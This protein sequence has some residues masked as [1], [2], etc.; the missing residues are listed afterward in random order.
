MSRI[1]GASDPPRSI[2]VVTL[3]GA[4]LPDLE[5][6]GTA[7]TKVLR[8]FGPRRSEQPKYEAACLTRLLEVAD[9]RW[10]QSP[11]C[12]EPDALGVSSW[13]AVWA[14]PT[15]SDPRHPPG[16]SAHAVDVWRETLTALGGDPLKAEDAAKR[17]ITHRESL[18]RLHTGTR[19]ALERI[20]TGHELWLAT[21]GSSALQRRKLRLAGLADL[22]GETFISAETGHLKEDPAFA[23]LIHYRAQ[24]RGLTIRAVIGTGLSDLALAAHGGW[25]A[26]HL[27]AEDISD[28][29]GPPGILHRDG[30]ENCLDIFKKGTPHVRP[31]IWRGVLDFELLGNGGGIHVILRREVLSI[32]W[33]G[34]DVCEFVAAIDREAF[35]RVWLNDDTRST[36]SLT[37]AGVTWSTRGTLM[38]MARDSGRAHPI[39]AVAVQYLHQM[40]VM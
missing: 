33:T 26:I 16:V 29:D 7:A 13:D 3:D 39:P 15:Y 37:T 4:L 22:F 17:L 38:C 1:P 23:E 34:D 21:H 35:R 28:Q 40:A 5:A 8:S 9:E 25:Q 6:F 14:D 18:V 24:A 20:A 11:L 10:R 36:A 2:V 31:R 32:W 30:L 12:E 27:C 19:D